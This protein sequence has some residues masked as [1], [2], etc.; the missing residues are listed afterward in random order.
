MQV[1]GSLRH[2]AEGNT[3]HDAAKF[4]FSKDIF[5][6]ETMFHVRSLGTFKEQTWTEIV[7]GAR[8]FTMEKKRKLPVLEDLDEMPLIEDI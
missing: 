4:K 7:S 1:G 2:F 6:K 8:A 5:Y 3:V